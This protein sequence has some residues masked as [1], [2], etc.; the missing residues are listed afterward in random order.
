M[1]LHKSCGRSQDGGVGCA[2]NH[3]GGFEWCVNSVAVDQRDVV[4]ANNEDSNL[5]A[6]GPGGEL[7]GRIFLNLSLGAAY[8][9]IALDDDGRIYT[10]NNGSLYGVG[11]A[12]AP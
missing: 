7:R 2:D 11:A 8:T 3:P 5:Y 4:Y 6:I 1:A 10:Q 9:S 12:H